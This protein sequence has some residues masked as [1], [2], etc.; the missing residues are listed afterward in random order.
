MDSRYVPA[1]S[2][3]RVRLGGRRIAAEWTIDTDDGYATLTSHEEIVTG[4]M[5]HAEVI[6]LSFY[7]G[8]TLCAT[9]EGYVYRENGFA[10]RWST[11]FR[12]IKLEVVIH[13]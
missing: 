1:R 11:S 7:R 6:P 5:R 13:D 10:G 3:G 8:S 2:P 4:K 12:M 9:G